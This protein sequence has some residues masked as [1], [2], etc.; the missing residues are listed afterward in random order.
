MDKQHALNLLLLLSS[1]ESWMF[2]VGKPFPDYLHDNLSDEV[3]NLSTIVLSDES[4]KN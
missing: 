2:A 3:L 4:E 1:I